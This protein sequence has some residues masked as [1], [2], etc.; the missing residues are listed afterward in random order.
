MSQEIVS[1]IA[2][3]KA[4]QGEE[5]SLERELL[6]LVGPSRAEG[7]CL[8]FDLHRSKQDKGLFFFYENWKSQDDLNK[9]L[10]EPHIQAFL[11]KKDDLLAEPISA[12][13]WIPVS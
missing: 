5:E 6:A 4:K 2:Q 9:H 8:N 12:T 7:G 3:L 10:E 1:V 13:F 11:A